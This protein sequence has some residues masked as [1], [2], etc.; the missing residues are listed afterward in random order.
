MLRR[1]EKE[2]ARDLRSGSS[3]LG[4]GKTGQVSGPAFVIVF[5]FW[6]DETI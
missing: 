6:W 1:T 5:S 4:G 3:R 2:T